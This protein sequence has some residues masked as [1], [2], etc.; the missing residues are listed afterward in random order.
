MWTNDPVG[1]YDRYCTEQ[2]RYAKRLPLCDECEERITDDYVWKIC[3][4][5]YCE[6]CAEKLFR[7]DNVEV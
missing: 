6:R 4:E 2:E 5:T 1:D 3:G 7:H